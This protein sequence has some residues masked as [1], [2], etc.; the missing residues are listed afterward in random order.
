MVA[1]LSAL[2]ETVNR[3]TTDRKLADE[4]QARMAE[5]KKDI[6]EKGYSSVNIDGKIFRIT[7]ISAKKDEQEKGKIL[8]V[9]IKKAG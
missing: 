2:S 7:S 5:I 8:G 4:I 6:A 9:K 1:S 3:S